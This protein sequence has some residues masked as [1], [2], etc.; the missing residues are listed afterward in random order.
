MSVSI[1]RRTCL[2]SL[3]LLMTGCAQ[4]EVPK[5]DEVSS[6][7]TPVLPVDSVVLEIA[8]ARLPLADVATYGSIWEEVDEQHFPADL[9]RELSANGVRV[10]IIGMQLPPK[11]KEILDA[12]S[13]SIIENGEDSSSGDADVDRADRRIQCR[14]GRRAKIVVAKEYATL[15]L[16]LLED[17][18]VRGLLLSDASCLFGLRVFPQGDGRARL[19]LTPEVEYGELKTKYTGRDG[20]VVPQVGHDR[21]VLDRMKLEAMLAPGQV[22]M[23]S[24]TPEAK[25]LGQSYFVETEGGTIFRRILLIRLAVTQHDDLFAPDQL[26]TPLAT[27]GE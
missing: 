1:T 11:L 19:D 2:A 23:I 6:L 20:A 7:P 22:L 8:F 17:S 14:N 9:R 10:G 24:T 25:G 26:V 15:S 18:R 5:V 12:G 21:V 16:L 4:W 13:G 27:P 3:G